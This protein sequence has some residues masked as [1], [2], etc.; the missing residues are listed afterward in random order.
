VDKD[1]VILAGHARY[2]AARRLG[3]P[4]IPIIRLAYLSPEQARCLAIADNKL[5]ELGRWDF[6][7][8]AVELGELSDA[9][10][11][12]TF[13]VELTGFETIDIDQIVKPKGRKAADESEFNRLPA[14][15][16]LISQPRDVW[17][18]GDHVLCCGDPADPHLY[19]VVL[20]AERASAALGSSVPENLASQTR[21]EVFG[22]TCG[23]I[24]SHM[25]PGGAV[26]YFV[27]WDQLEFLL[28]AAEPT[29]GKPIEMIVW[30][31]A[32]G[33][34]GPIY[35]AHHEL[36]AMYV[37]GNVPPLHEGQLKR[38]GRHEAVDHVQALWARCRT[39]QD[40]PIF[41]VDSHIL[42]CAFR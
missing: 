28:A 9:K 15:G 36:V 16:P 14:P 23:L 31:D 20:E 38:R 17:V 35:Q 12:L 22:T 4:E 7:Q 39:R 27:P 19:E 26:Y 2:T 8:L 24:G 11:D 13:D 37:A 25:Q 29:F 42:G 6:D 34:R 5:A 41:P 3:L 30:A 10:L 18:C 40:D 21:R 32:K 1:G 33:T